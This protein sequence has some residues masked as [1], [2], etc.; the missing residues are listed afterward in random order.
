MKGNTEWAR[1]LRTIESEKTPL[2]FS[3]YIDGIS[4]YNLD[5][6]HVSVQL[7]SLVGENWTNK[8]FNA[9]RDKTSGEDENGFELWRKLYVTHEG[10]ARTTHV[11]G[12]GSFR[13]F[14]ACD[15]PEDLGD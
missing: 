10:G 6:Y 15:K 9:R 2:N 3:R 4:G 1:L 8:M 11:S 7:W 12:M 5:P 14:P 13:T